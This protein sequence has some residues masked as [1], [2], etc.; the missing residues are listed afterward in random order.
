MLSFLSGRESSVHS[1][2][3][4][5]S[6]ENP[7]RFRYPGQ[8]ARC[9][10]PSLP[11]AS[12]EDADGLGPQCSGPRTAASKSSILKYLKLGWQS[13]HVHIDVLLKQ[14]VFLEIGSL[15]HDCTT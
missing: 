10:L 4:E 1:R 15:Y 14:R 5:A 2:I 3:S 11:G 12:A 13:S 7:K 8:D 6:K 9:L